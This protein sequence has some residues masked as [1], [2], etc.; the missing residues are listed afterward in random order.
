MGIALHSMDE[1]EENEEYLKKSIAC[2]ERAL[3]AYTRDDTPKRWAAAKN[4]LGSVLQDFGKRIASNSILEEAVAVLLAALEI[5]TVE[6]SPIEFATTQ[7]NLGNTYTALSELNEELH[8]LDEA[9]VAYEKSL[10]VLN[11]EITPFPWALTHYNLGCAYRTSSILHQEP[12]LLIPS[13]K[14]FLKAWAYFRFVNSIHRQSVEQQLS[15]LCNF[16][17][18]SSLFA[19]LSSALAEDSELLEKFLVYRDSRK[20]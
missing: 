16:P 10:N 12:Q 4:N 5:R 19:S 1:I 9:I 3:E 7:I 6:S 20:E 2:H 18:E 15:D 14:C 8:Y 17:K 11:Q 13:L